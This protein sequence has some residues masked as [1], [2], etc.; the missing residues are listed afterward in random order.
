MPFHHKPIVKNRRRT[1]RF[2]FLVIPCIVSTALFSTAVPA[3]SQSARQVPIARNAPFPGTPPANPNASQGPEFDSALVG[4]DAD[5]SDD[6]AGGPGISVNRTISKA[7]G[8]P[9]SHHGSAK[10]K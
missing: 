3:Q 6:D 10:A 7:P 2:R 4:N 8:S 9:M 1:M 5:S